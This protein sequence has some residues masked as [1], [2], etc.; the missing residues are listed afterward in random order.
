[1]G[2]Q[3]GVLLRLVYSDHCWRDVDVVLHEE[4]KGRSHDFPPG[5][6][7]RAKGIEAFFGGLR[8][9]PE[10]DQDINVRIGDRV[11]SRLRAE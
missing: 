8:S 2:H 3:R 9:F 4:I 1:M 6:I 11:P 7:S 5:G 10:D